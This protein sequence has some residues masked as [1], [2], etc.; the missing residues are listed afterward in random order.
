MRILSLYV[1]NF[2][3]LQGY[4][5]SLTAGLNTLL[6]PN[7]WGKSSLA[8]FIK[9]MLYGL[10]V[11][12]RRS[13]TENERKRY[14]PW[15]GGVYGGSLDIEI[16][17][18][19]L[20][21]ER[22]FGQKESEDTLALTDLQTG[23][24]YPTDGLPSLG[25]AWFGV[26]AAAY[27][28]STY[29]SQR[30]TDESDGNLSIHAKL[31][32]L[33]DATDDIG[34]FD[35]AMELLEKQRKYY[36]LSGGRRGAIAQLEESCKQ[37][38]RQMQACIA[39]RSAAAQCE[40]ILCEQTRALAENR[41][42]SEALLREEQAQH[43]EKEAAA[44]RL[45]C[46]NLL[47]FAQKEADE[48]TRA[49]ASLGG[50]LPDAA[51]IAQIETL[52]MEYQTHLTAQQPLLQLLDE[53]SPSVGELTALR[54]ML[55]E[56]LPS[57]SQLQALRDAAEAARSTQQ[58]LKDAVA[59]PI[60]D[61]SDKYEES[62][63][64]E[65]IDALRLQRFYIRYPVEKE[66]SERALTQLSQAAA[67]AEAQLHRQRK[68]VGQATPAAVVSAVLGAVGCGLTGLLAPALLWIPLALTLIALGGFTAW[69][70]L[71][72]RRILPCVKAW[73]AAQAAVAEE[74]EKR[75]GLDRLWSAS[76]KRIERA[77]GVRVTDAQQ[78]LELLHDW[79][80]RKTEAQARK[81]AQLAA[82]Q[83]REQSIALLRQQGNEA[84]E[85]MRRLW[86]WGEMPAAADAPV[87]VE[88]LA[89]QCARQRVL[90]GE[91]AA[92]KQQLDAL[93]EQC[94]V[95]R[96]Q[97]RAALAACP[98]CPERGA[99]AWLRER[100]EAAKRSKE[101]HAQL[102][103]DAEAF[104]ATHGVCLDTLDLTQAEE[105]TAAGTD[106]AAARA[107]LQDEEQSLRQQLAA[108]RREMEEHQLAASAYE[109]LEAELQQESARLEQA[110]AALA[111]VQTTQKYLTQA[112]EQLSG[113]Y[114]DRMKQRFA[115][116]LSA[117]TGKDDAAFTMDGQFAVKL[118][119]AGVSRPTEAFSTGW[120]DVIALCARLSLVDALFEE[121]QPFLVLDDPFAN[122]DD[123]TAAR[124]AQLLQHAAERY[125]I[126]YLTC[127]SSR[128]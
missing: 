10:P 110:K 72:R 5:L 39:H 53:N 14:T 20:R 90:A 65:E 51:Q 55:G 96:E 6:K 115:A 106:Y 8:V 94:R 91:L 47:S 7:G 27:E 22:T 44:H 63:P 75:E 127:H 61:A 12:G 113:R 29:L 66:R 19:Q 97:Y 18:R 78:A 86:R 87:A 64:T 105:E 68:K 9:A 108:T 28:R 102:R 32:A 37:L 16:G 123:D 85:Q 89:Q 62:I 124:A 52:E 45:H 4:S 69:A 117:L 93:R 84:L 31:N 34:S 112:R 15:Q 73:E 120:R 42:Q 24:C 60:A 109:A 58:R 36:T 48:Y 43:K 92:A 98:D 50:T 30:E 2:G 74:T 49:L 125:Q 11:S 95:L 38:E 76:C 119:R 56:Q 111:T 21:I 100:T 99:A 17:G 35:A 128:A 71:V 104:A 26:D 25:E 3:T 126:L 59:A 46:R 121:E 13:L 70:L 114:L 77:M 83:E 33:V 1:E 57:E 103:V 88:R 82:D 116:Y 101:R 23:V 40:P 80:R 54:A 41:R 107:R 81:A 118:R 67:Q 122:L 79:E